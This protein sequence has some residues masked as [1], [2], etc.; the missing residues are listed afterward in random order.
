M[1]SLVLLPYSLASIL[2]VSLTA[3]DTGLSKGSGKEPEELVQLRKQYATRALQSASPLAEQYSA[4]LTTVMKETGA[5][6]DY[7]Q[8][9]AAQRRRE[10]LIELYSKALNETKLTNVIVLKPADARVAGSVNYDRTTAEL[11]NWKSVGS[12]ASWDISKIIPG[13]YDIAVTYSV[14]EFGDAPVRNNP[15]ASRDLSLETGGEFEFFEDTSLSGSAANHRTA[16]V[17]STGAWT[18]FTTINLAPIQLTRS[19]ARFALK[20][21]RARGEGGVMHLKEIRLVPVKAANSDQATPAALANG[22]ESPKD[23]FTKLKESYLTRLKSV[24]PPVLS[25]YTSK[26]KSLGSIATAKNDAELTEI[27]NSEITRTQSMLESP[28]TAAVVLAG[29]GGNLQASGFEEWKNVHYKPSPQN[30]GDR[31]L[32]EYKGQDIPVRLLSVTSPLLSAEAVTRNKQHAAYFGITDEDTVDLAKRAREFTEAFLQNK[33]FRI[34]TRGMKDPEGLLFVNVV[35][36]GVGDYAGVLVDNGLASVNNSKVKLKEGKAA[37]ESTLIALREREA[38]AKAR[39]IPP[40]AWAMV[41]E[42]PLEKK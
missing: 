11:V 15:L 37:E 29:A 20:I 8:A 3:Q 4:A 21:T 40:G 42:A 23:E 18:T 33:P 31:F 28:E 19:S 36:E 27:V 32:V 6:G 16:Q 35:P 13:S 10:S 14:A 30:G 22:E 12:S 5:S 24:V 1:K 2:A 7:D 41:P 38:A 25:A 26:L 34:Y 17:I 9:L 39:P